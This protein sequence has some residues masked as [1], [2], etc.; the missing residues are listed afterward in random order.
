[1]KLTFLQ[2][3]ELKLHICKMLDY[4]QKI[5]YQNKKVSEVYLQMIADLQRSEKLE[6]NC[7]CR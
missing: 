5:K 7:S 6:V 2:L 4:P 1:M 3:A